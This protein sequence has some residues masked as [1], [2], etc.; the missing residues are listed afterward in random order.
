MVGFQ[1][2]RPPRRLGAA[3]VE[4][5][6]QHAHRGHGQRERAQAGS[7]ERL[8]QK[9]H[10]LRVGLRAG[11]ADALD[12]DLRVLARRG[13]HL[14]LRLAEHALGVAEAQG[15]L[16]VGQAR[17]AHARHLQGHVG[18]H[19]QQVATRVEEP[20]RRAGQPPARLHDVHD[21]ER[22][23]LD[24]DVSARGEDLLNGM[25]DALA[26]ERLVRKHVAEP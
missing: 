12:A 16:D 7:L 8:R 10:H 13:L 20:K 1:H 5:R 21:L 17:G 22:R 25:H 15:A 11:H 3:A 24:G 9:A 18:T 26:H 2:V 4:Q 14:R 19:G 6:A 23:R